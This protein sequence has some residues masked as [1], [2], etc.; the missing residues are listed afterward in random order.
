MSESTIELWKRVN[1]Y[2]KNH[3]GVFAF[4]NTFTDI[5]IPYFLQAIQTHLRIV[6]TDRVTDRQFFN[7]NSCFQMPDFIRFEFESS[8]YNLDFTSTIEQIE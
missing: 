3:F 6:L 2:C 1:S 7:S 4:Q 5:H 8:I